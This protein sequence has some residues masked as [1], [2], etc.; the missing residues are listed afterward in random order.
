[1]LGVLEAAVVE[2]AEAAELGLDHPRSGDL[3]AV[4]QHGSWFVHDWWLDE[5]R[6]PD[7]ARMVDIHRKPGYDPR[8]LFLSSRLRLAW[9]LLLM[10]LG[11]RTTLDV[12]PLDAGLVRGSHGRTDPEPGQEPV[13]IGLDQ[14]TP[15]GETIP[16][17][18]VRSILMGAMFG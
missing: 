12:I 15:E 1:M 14:S 2:V 16:C 8:E 10:K 13:L 3:I 17:E 18:A 6:A 4:A 11:V 5:D 9:K 7:Y